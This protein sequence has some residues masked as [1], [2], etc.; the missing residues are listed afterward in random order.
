MTELLAGT[1]EGQLDGL[2]SS[3]PGAAVLAGATDVAA[4]TGRV[5]TAAAVAPLKQ[6]CLCTRAQ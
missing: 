4:G 5:A 6:V 3:A 2:A 1:S